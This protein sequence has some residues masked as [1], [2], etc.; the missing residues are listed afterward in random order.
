[1]QKDYEYYYDGYA[2]TYINPKNNLLL[3]FPSWLE[4]DVE[5]NKSDDERISIAFN[6]NAK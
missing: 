3:L 2:Y 6:I 1:M 4:H 5:E